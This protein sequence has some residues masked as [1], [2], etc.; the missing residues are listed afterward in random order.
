MFL[1]VGDN[2]NRSTKQI[3]TRI[4]DLYYQESRDRI[5]ASQ[6]SFILEQAKALRA[7]GVHQRFPI[8]AAEMGRYKR[9]VSRRYWYL[10]LDLTNN[11]PDLIPMKKG[12]WELVDANQKSLTSLDDIPYDA[13]AESLGCSRKALEKYW[14]EEG[15]RKYVQSKLPPW[16]LKDSDLLLAKVAE[17][18]ED[19]EKCVDFKDIFEE[20][21]HGKCADWQH[22]RDHF[23]TIRREVPFYMLEDLQ[24]VVAAARKGLNQKLAEKEASGDLEGEQE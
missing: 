22:L 8:I 11:S 6:D 21:F 24:S 2:L 4:K 13:F 10:K 9:Q 18:G 1:Y 16:T 5:P 17:S 23:M 3:Y 20:N 14:V 7:E 15:K 12:I 19:E